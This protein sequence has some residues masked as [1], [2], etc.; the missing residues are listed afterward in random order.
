MR[1]AAGLTWG[2]GVSGSENGAG[3]W[4]TDVEMRDEAG[5]RHW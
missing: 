2:T 5:G 1:R 3:V 4:V